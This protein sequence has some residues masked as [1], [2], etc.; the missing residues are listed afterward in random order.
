[1]ELHV[2]IDETLALTLRP[3]H[4][5]WPYGESIVMHDGCSKLSCGLEPDSDRG[6]VVAWLEH[7][8]PENGHH[9]RFLSK[10]SSRMREFG[11]GERV[12]N[13]GQGLWGNAEREYTGKVELEA[14]DNNGN[15]TEPHQSDELVPINDD[16]VGVL[17][18]AAGRVAERGSM[19]P[20]VKTTLR[21]HGLSGTRGKICLRW[22]RE[23]RTWMV[24]Q[25]NEL[26]SHILKEES[27]REWLPAEAAIESYC[28]RALGLAG[29]TTA[30][31]RSRLYRGIAT[32]VSQRTD[33]VECGD[34]NPIGRTHQ[35]EW[36]QAIRMLP[37]N[38]SDEGPPEKDWRSLF[39][40]FAAHAQQ[41]EHEQH[42]LAIAIA[43]LTL[44]GCADTHRRNVGVQHVR[45]AEG[46]KIVLAPLYDCSSIEGTEW[47]SAKRM[48]IPIAGATGFD[49]VGERHW[50]NLAQASAVS[51]ALI[52]GAVRETA[53]K[54]PDALRDAA[55]TSEEHDYTK[56]RGARDIRIETIERE[57]IERCKRTLNELGTV[58]TTTKNRETRPRPPW[59]RSQNRER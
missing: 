40:L 15:R 43:G 17:V 4:S 59:P 44:I 7:L 26:S 39:K 16:I 41:P 57:A 9:D 5:Q 53:R 36:S 28:Q 2:K 46:E 10:A 38:K 12:E 18:A 11:Y 27:S 21:E 45:G 37:Y 8:V 3:K 31:T 48:V 20:Q 32:V 33:R 35:E 1:M 47:T 25:G 30:R 23:R 22:N 50:R 49:E 56:E 42:K 29:V 34:A 6:E 19:P 24:P 54:L 14:C 51:S 13:V 58:T 52:L 55:K